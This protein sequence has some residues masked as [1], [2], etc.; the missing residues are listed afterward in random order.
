MGTTKPRKTFFR[1]IYESGGF[2]RSLDV[3]LSLLLVLSFSNI[4]QYAAAASDLASGSQS[5][6]PAQELSAVATT[7]AAT[8]T[9]GAETP[10][11]TNAEELATSA[12]ETLEPVA[13]HFPPLRLRLSL[14][15]N[16]YAT[17]SAVTLKRL[18]RPAVNSR[19]RS[20]R[21]IHQPER[22]TLQPRARPPRGTPM[23]APETTTRMGRLS[24]DDLGGAKGDV[25][26]DAIAERSRPRRTRLHVQGPPAQNAPMKAP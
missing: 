22:W 17:T 2:R 25:S 1:K 19:S 15:R 23:P 13:E 3:F 26:A 12:T 20:A 10:A 21:A 24:T 18:R 14:D 4:L 11:A 16:V 9:S 6:S 5:T 8:G 7:D